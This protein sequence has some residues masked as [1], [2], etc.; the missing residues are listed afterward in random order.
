MHHIGYQ[1]TPDRSHHSQGQYAQKYGLPQRRQRSVAVDHDHGIRTGGWVNGFGQ[2]HITQCHRLRQHVNPE[3]ITKALKTHNT[4]QR[5]TQVPAKQGT[6]LRSGRACQ[7]EQE[8][9]RATE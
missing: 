9:R 7:A 3:C 1:P 5:A 6:G 4:D 8:N 2:Q